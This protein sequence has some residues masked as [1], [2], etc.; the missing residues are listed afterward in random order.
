M[1]YSSGASYEGEWRADKKC[2]LGI[3]QWRATDEL[4]S[5]QIS[6]VVFYTEFKNPS[7][8]MGERRTA[9]HW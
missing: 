2:G 1:K 4:Y 5:G 9:R 8:S 7:R 3:M 6:N